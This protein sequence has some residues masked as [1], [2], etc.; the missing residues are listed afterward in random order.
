MSR[1]LRIHRYVIITEEGDSPVYDTPEEARRFKATVPKDRIA[2]WVAY[3][4]VSIQR[5]VDNPH[6]IESY[7][8]QESQCLEIEDMRE[9][10]QLA[11]PEPQTS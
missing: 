9:D 10:D 11:F 1:C 2:V 6:T 5:L 4:E 3:H 8:H 7:C